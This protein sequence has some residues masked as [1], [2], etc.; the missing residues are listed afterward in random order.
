MKTDQVL[1]LLALID[2]KHGSRVGD[3]CANLNIL[4][5]ELPALITQARDRGFMVSI[6]NGPEKS[7]RMVIM[8]RGARDK[9][10]AAA[11][12]YVDRQECGL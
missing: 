3:L 5:P 9:I 10:M 12:D 4:R 2:P 1:E 7:G 11:T 6:H 8:D